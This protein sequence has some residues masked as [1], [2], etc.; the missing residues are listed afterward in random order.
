MEPK[1]ERKN[2]RKMGPMKERRKDKICVKCPKEK[3]K[4]VYA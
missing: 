1:K 3:R 2:V 4:E